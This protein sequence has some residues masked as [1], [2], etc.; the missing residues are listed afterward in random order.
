M[1]TVF[2][3]GIPFKHNRY[4]ISIVGLIETLKRLFVIFVKTEVK[5]VKYSS[6]KA[7][8]YSAGNNNYK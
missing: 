7:R 4:R 8:T 5:T 3:T 1:C 2:C 6:R